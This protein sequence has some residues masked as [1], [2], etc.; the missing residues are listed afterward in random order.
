MGYSQNKQSEDIILTYNIHSD[1]VTVLKDNVWNTINIHRH[2]ETNTFYTINAL[3]AAIKLEH[4]GQSGTQFKLNWE[5]YTYS[6]LLNDRETKE[7]VIHPTVL[8]E[9]VENAY[10]SY[11]EDRPTE[12]KEPI[13]QQ[14]PNGNSIYQ[15]SGNNWQI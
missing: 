7:L 11:Y 8:L 10:K 9:V 2:K 4:N 3:N 14:A 1:N 6:I 12:H 13:L 15:E 5:N